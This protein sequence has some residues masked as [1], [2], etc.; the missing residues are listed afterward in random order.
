MG[1]ADTRR[2]G[3]RDPQAT[4]PATLGGRQAKCSNWI[5]GELKAAYD[6]HEWNQS[7]SQSGVI[8]TALGVT[9]ICRPE[10]DQGRES[11]GDYAR[12]AAEGDGSDGKGSKGYLSDWSLAA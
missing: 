11:G 3:L 4:R 6:V 2:P 7:E 12:C 10:Q 9:G 8:K 5:K 1:Q